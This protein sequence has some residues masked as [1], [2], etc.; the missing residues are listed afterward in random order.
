MDVRLRISA[1]WS[2]VLFLFAFVDIFT[3]YRA[4]LRAEIESGVIAGFIINQGFLVFTTIYIMIPALMVTLT[5]VLAPA[6]NRRANMGVA[7]LY[8]LSIVAA[9]IGEWPHY[10]IASAVELVLLAGVVHHARQIGKA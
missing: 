7:G 10:L 5:L 1:M 4:D 2:S 3:F 9:A 6:W 8:G